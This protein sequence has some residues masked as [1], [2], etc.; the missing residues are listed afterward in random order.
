MLKY[1]ISISSLSYQKNLFRHF[2]YH[3]KDIKEDFVTFLAEVNEKE[4][5]KT[6]KLKI[7]QKIIKLDKHANHR[8]LNKWKLYEE[9]KKIVPNI[10]SIKIKYYYFT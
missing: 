10:N 6:Y 8:Q 7:K 3:Q 1:K 4:K 9:E 5:I 2:K